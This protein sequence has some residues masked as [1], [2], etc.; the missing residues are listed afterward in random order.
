[1]HPE[2]VQFVEAAHFQPFISSP[3]IRANLHFLWK[4]PYVYLKTL[5][6]L[7]R[8]N[9]GSFKFFTGVIGIFPKSVLFAYQMRADNVQHVH[10]HFASHPAAAGFH[11]SS[12]WL[13]SLIAS[14]LMARIFIVTDICCV[15][16]LLKQHLLQRSRNTTKN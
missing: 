13:V 6:D 9:W 12:A 1:M 2:A 15:K 4:K 8:A 16:R 10:A 5:W 14:P 3:I 11:H 7:L